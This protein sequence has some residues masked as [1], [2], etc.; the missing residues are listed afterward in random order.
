M[1]FDVRISIKDGTAIATLE[2]QIDENAAHTLD[3][4]LKNFWLSNPAA[5]HTVLD[6]DDVQFITSAGFRVIFASYKK[7]TAIGGTLRVINSS[8]R[9][10]EAFETLGLTAYIPIA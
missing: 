3:V 5:K 7:L 6:L 10:R 4:A 1:A 8:E 2:G 9:V